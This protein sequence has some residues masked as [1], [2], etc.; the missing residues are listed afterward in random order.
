MSFLFKMLI[1]APINVFSTLGL[2]AP[3]GPVPSGLGL[4]FFTSPA[5]EG[6]DRVPL[7]LMTPDGSAFKLAGDPNQTWRSTYDG[8]PVSPQHQALLAANWAAALNDINALLPA[9][10]DPY[11]ILAPTRPGIFPTVNTSTTDAINWVPPRRDPLVLDLDGNGITTSGINPAAPI[12]FD[13]DGDGTLTATGWIAAGEA[14]V[15]R[16]LNG[17]GRID[18]GRELFG[19]NTVLTRGPNV[20][21]LASNGFTAL[22]DLDANAA[23]VADG[24]FDA[25]DAAFTSVKL[26]KDLN[27]NGV[28]EAGELFSFADLG[29]QHINLAATASNVP[30]IGGNTQTFAGT[31]TR[32]GGTTGQRGMGTTWLCV[33]RSRYRFKMKRPDCQHFRCVLSYL[34]NCEKYPENL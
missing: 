30:L 24:K 16:D 11:K 5:G 29:V 3:L 31:F 32:G 25:S 20:G 19:D 7:V 13:Q 9:F 21:Q 22:A 6:S 4:L 26:W 28:S 15:V 23:G 10:F 8:E 34:I 14:I 12:L 17:N 27:Q 18:S 33:A 1:S 2:G